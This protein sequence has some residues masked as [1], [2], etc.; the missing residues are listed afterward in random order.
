[1]VR[2]LTHA[3]GSTMTVRGE[4]ALL[5]GRGRSDRAGRGHDPDRVGSGDRHPQARDPQH[6]GHGGRSAR[7]GWGDKSHAGI[8]GIAEAVDKRRRHP[9]QDRW[10][11]LPLCPGR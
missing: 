8:A 6:P 5:P 7:S 9:H 2:D 4:V 3:S 11:P 1:M 10:R